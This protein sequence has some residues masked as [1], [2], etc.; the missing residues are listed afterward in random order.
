M[1]NST[2][3]A[4]M[5]SQKFLP[6]ARSQRLMLPLG[7]VPTQASQA[8]HSPLRRLC[9]SSFRSTG[10]RWAQAEQPG[11]QFSPS[12]CSC[13]KGSTG[14]R[15][16]TAPIGHKNWQKE[17]GCTA[18]PI[19]ISTNS[20]MPRPKP[21]GGVRRAV[22][23]EN[24]SHGLQPVSRLYTPAV[25]RPTMTASTTNLTFWPRRTA[26]SG[27]WNCFLRWSSFFCTRPE[28]HHTPSPRLPKAHTWPQKKRPNRM[29]NP[30]RPRSERVKLSSCSTSPW[31]MRRNSCF[32]PL[33]PATKAPG[34]AIKNI[35]CT[36]ARSQARCFRVRCFFWAAVSG[37]FSVVCI[38][39]PPFPVRPALHPAGPHR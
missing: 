31:P 6:R 35:S 39:P 3:F 7:Q 21:A 18:M 16:N 25:H 11:M 36:A 30:H 2:A 28:S 26:F 38:M 33:K 27:S 12:R 15:A 13:A 9:S 22:R 17:R 32:T 19:R 1:K 4:S 29:V 20:A 34:I 23:R 10:Q 24:T 8:M 37:F 5:G 14:S